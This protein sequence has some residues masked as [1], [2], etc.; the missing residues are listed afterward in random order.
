MQTTEQRRLRRKKK[1]V[2][3]R[4]RQIEAFASVAGM[5]ASLARKDMRAIQMQLDEYSSRADGS[6]GYCAR[7]AVRSHA[8]KAPT[9]IARKPDGDSHSTPRGRAGKSVGAKNT[10]DP[11]SR[12]F[13]ARQTDD[14]LLGLSA[15]HS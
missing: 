7:F 9:Q 4:L 8:S 13:Y 6:R 1:T 14:A 10:K 2:S 11:V 12:A 15:E 5:L 3:Y